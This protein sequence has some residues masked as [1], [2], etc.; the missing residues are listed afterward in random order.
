MKFKYNIRNFILVLFHFIIGF[1][2][3]V[4]LIFTQFIFIWNGFG[5]VF[6]VVLS[7]I[8]AFLVMFSVV[9]IFRHNYK[10]KFSDYKLYWNSIFI[11]WFIVNVIMVIL[12]IP[13]DFL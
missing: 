7:I 3:Y 4:P 1:V 13:R 12:I 8:L 9:L 2:F 11:I 6:S 10:D 5:H